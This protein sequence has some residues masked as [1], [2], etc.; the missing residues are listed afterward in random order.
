[1]IIKLAI[2]VKPFLLKLLPYQFWKAIKDYLVTHKENKLKCAG[3]KGED[4]RYNL[5]HGHKFNRWN[6]CSDRFGRKLQDFGKNIEAF[7]ISF[8]CL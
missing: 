6:Q 7:F 5:I 1:M 8:C 2:K 4:V 3:R